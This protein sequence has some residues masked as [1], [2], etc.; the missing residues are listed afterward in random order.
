MT[1]ARWQPALLGAPSTGAWAL[2][3]C[4]QQFLADA[5]GVLFPRDWLSKQDLPVSSEHGLGHF[6]GRPVYLLELMEPAALPGAFWQGLRQFM[7]QTDDHELFR[8]LGYAAQIGTWASQHRFCGRCGGPMRQHGAERAMHC[9]ACGLHQYPR[10]SPSMIVL[11]HRGDELLLARSPRFA[12]GVYST[13]AGFV[14]PGESVEQC[15][16]REVFEEVGV[17]VRDLHYIGSQ[18]WPFPHSLMLGFHARYVS[19]EIV[20]QPGEI[21]DARWFH[22][23]DLPPLPASRSIA[24]YLI[25]LYVAQRR[26]TELP[27]LLG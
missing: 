16:E 17:T 9:E 13:L 11:V 26:G 15:V 19:G 27:Q 21:E 18:G 8:M 2:V 12:S 5:N 25:D 1:I 23:D 4:Q 6:E 24:R 14:E 10:L 20:P 3:H 22:L 7:L